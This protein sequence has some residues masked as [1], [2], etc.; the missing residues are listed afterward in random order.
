VQPTQEQNKTRV[1]TLCYR[2]CILTSGA[3]PNIDQGT[4]LTFQT[5]AFQATSATICHPPVHDKRVAYST[6][7][8]ACPKDRFCTQQHRFAHLP[9]S[10]NPLPHP[11]HHLTVWMTHFV[12]SHDLSHIID[13]TDHGSMQ[14]CCREISGPAMPATCLSCL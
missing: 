10:L 14:Q 3:A 7:C 4:L 6:S 11:W 13:L 9:F 5:M 2:E 12:T 8:T 1:L